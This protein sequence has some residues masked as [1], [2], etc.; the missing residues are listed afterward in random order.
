MESTKCSMTELEKTHMTK[1]K[2]K[3]ESNKYPDLQVKINYQWKQGDQY[4]VQIWRHLMR[5]FAASLHRPLFI[6]WQDFLQTDHLMA[7]SSEIGR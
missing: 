6:K 5:D 4:S 2:N 1:F 3:M 7:Q